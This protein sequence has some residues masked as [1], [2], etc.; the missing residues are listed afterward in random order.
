MDSQKQKRQRA[1]NTQRFFIVAI[2]V[3]IDSLGNEMGK[4]TLMIIPEAYLQSDARFR[5]PVLAG[6]TSRAYYY[7]NLDNVSTHMYRIVERRHTGNIRG[8]FKA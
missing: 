7:P 2:A 3:R 8:R 1:D 5:W 4:H 6:D